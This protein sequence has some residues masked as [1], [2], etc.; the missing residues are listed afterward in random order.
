MLIYILQY[1]H[2]PS[3]CL[4]IFELNN[5]DVNLTNNYSS[6]SQSQQMNLREII[7]R[8]TTKLADAERSSIEIQTILFYERAKLKCK[9]VPLFN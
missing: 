9:F 3:Q 8:H 2:F 7:P 4:R 5:G 1:L 6:S